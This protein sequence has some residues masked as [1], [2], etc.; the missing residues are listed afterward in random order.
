LYIFYSI[1]VLNFVEVGRLT[2][3]RSPQEKK[4]P[5]IVGNIILTLYTAH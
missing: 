1:V 3:N 5:N 2:T 4:G